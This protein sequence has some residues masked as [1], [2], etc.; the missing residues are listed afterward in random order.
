MECEE[1][2]EKCY[3]IIGRDP[4][5]KICVEWTTGGM[6][7]GSCWNDGADCPVS[8]ESPKELVALDEILEVLAPN[9]SFL[10]YRHILRDCVTESSG[11]HNDYYG[12]Y[13]DY[14]RKTLDLDALYEELVNMEII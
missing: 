6:T 9:L 8:A 11:T 14:V 12:N 5:D 13:T 7:G 3:E 2:K 1:F 10:Q 4:G